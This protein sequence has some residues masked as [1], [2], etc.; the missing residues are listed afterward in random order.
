MHTEKEFL[1]KR[2]DR[3]REILL[4]YK[5]DENIFVALSSDGYHSLE[6]LVDKDFPYKKKLEDYVLKKVSEELDLNQEMFNKK[7]K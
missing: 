7:Y 5:C 2:I 4:K 1:S 6:V 3:L